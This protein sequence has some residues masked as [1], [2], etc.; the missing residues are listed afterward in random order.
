M[1]LDHLVND[2]SKL[3]VQSDSALKEGD[4]L[5]QEEKEKMREGLII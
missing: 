5:F 3:D 4:S 2:L 1:S